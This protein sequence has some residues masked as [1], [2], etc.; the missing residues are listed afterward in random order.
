MLNTQVQNIDK[1][2]INQFSFSSTDVLKDQTL[3]FKRRYNLMRAL[4][5]GNLAK[6]HVLIRFID[7]AG[8]EMRT[9]ATV[10]AVTHK[11]VI[12]KASAMIPISSILCVEL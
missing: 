8:L 7:S 10:W 6:Q 3:K 5:L 1:S 2:L 11:H 12:L 4:K 9:R